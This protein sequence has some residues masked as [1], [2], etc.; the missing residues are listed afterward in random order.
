[1]HPFTSIFS[2]KV[3]SL[4]DPV[5]ELKNVRIQGARSVIA[6]FVIVFSIID[7]R[8]GLDAFQIKATTNE[9]V[10]TIATTASGIF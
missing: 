2:Y 8:L 5:H 9:H 4:L 7:F 3:S 1:M 10:Q 6:V